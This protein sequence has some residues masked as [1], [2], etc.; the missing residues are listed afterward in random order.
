MTISAALSQNTFVSTQN[1][2]I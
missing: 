2:L 1:F